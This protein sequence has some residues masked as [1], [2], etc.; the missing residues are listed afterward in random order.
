[1]LCK[2]IIKKALTLSAFFIGFLLLQSTFAENCANSSLS[3]PE[4]AVVKWVYDGD[5][6]L[7][8]D[9]R[10]IRVI[11]IDTPEVKHHKQKQQAFGAK[12]REALRELLKKNNYQ[13]YLRYGK[14]RY[15]RYSRVLAHVYTP[16]GINISNWLLEK[17]F[18][19]TLSIPP[20]ILLADCYKHSETTAKKHS[21]RIWRLK[22]HKV[23]TAENLSVRKKGFV[24]L[25]GK[26]TKVK[27][28][29]KS[30]MMEFGS[31]NQHPITIKITKKNSVYFKEM[32]LDKLLGRVV[33]ISGILKKRHGKRIIYLN[34]PTQ[35]NTLKQKGKRVAPV[36]K[37]S[38]SNEK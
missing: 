22:S 38:L 29:K 35:L 17:G 3:S 11:G 5:T 7:L 34:Y 12:A 18:A 1:M 23:L 14:E 32:R 37:W 8:T 15:D 16:D 9:K 4:R 10:K 36:I 21:L 25:K 28:R 13:I 26:I 20:N 6:L 33:E 30:I 19:R 31:N 27:F 2:Q 24:R